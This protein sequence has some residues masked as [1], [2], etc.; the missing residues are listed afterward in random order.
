MK[1]QRI[2]VD[3]HACFRPREDFEMQSTPK[4]VAI[5]MDGNRRWARSRGLTAWTGHRRGVECLEALLPSVRKAGIETLTLFGFATANWQRP[6]LEVNH[7]LRLAEEALARFTPR[8]VTERISVQVIG[9]RDRL[10]A[11]LRSAIARAECATAGGSRSLRIAIDYSSREAIVRAA[12]KLDSNA[13]ATDLNH[14]LGEAGDVDLLIR[15]GREQ[16]LSDFLLWECAFAELY[17]PDLHWPDFSPGALDEALDWYR[18]R[19]RRFG[20]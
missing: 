12:R 13:E 6:R 10:P 3:K 18:L 2:G 7:I 1:Q 20:R 17:F 14:A 19:N 8:C 11:G 16:R 5:I 9:R 4:H 15:T